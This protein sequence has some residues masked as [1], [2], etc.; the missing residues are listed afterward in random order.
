MLA[1]GDGIISLPQLRVNGQ[2]VGNGG[3]V[4]ELEDFGEL[5]EVLEVSG[6]RKHIR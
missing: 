2:Y 3:T 4:Q 6:R 1:H 5:D